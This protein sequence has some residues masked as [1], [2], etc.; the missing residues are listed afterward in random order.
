MNITIEHITKAYNLYQKL[1]ETAEKTEALYEEAKSAEEKAQIVVH[2]SNEK[3]ASTELIRLRVATV[4]AEAKRRILIL[5]REKAEAQYERFV[6]I[7][8]L[9]SLKLSPEDHDLLAKQEMRYEGVIGG[10]ALGE[11]VKSPAYLGAGDAMGEPAMFGEIP[12]DDANS[13]SFLDID[14]RIP[15]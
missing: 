3:I 10:G 7:H 8:A 14:T 13:S 9:N 11:Y 5:R 6:A 15:A 2:N 12:I 4:T 1:T